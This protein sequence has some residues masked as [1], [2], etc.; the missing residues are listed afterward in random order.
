VIAAGTTD[1]IPGHESV[2]PSHAYS[3][4]GGFTAFRSST[5]LQPPR[6][7][8]ADPKIEAIKAYREET[9]AGLADAK[10]NG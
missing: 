4:S 3:P 2:P 9:G 5:A 7:V 6:Q 1:R 10:K 8:A